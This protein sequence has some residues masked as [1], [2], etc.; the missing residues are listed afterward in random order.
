MSSRSFKP[1]S[2]QVSYYTRIHLSVLMN[3]NYP[4]QDSE[5]HFHSPNRFPDPLISP[6]LPSSARDGTL[7]Y[8][9]YIATA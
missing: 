4:S 5:T 3:S 8:L 9:K 6:G 1:P 2:P 7:L